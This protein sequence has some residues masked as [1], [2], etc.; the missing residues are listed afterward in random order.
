MSSEVDEDAVTPKQ[1][2][3][4]EGSKQELLKCLKESECVKVCIIRYLS[5]C[6]YDSIL[7]RNQIFVCVGVGA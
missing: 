5:M 6:V 1:R 7:L 2:R 4:C 3:A